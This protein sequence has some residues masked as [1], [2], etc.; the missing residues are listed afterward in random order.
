[1]HPCALVVAN[2]IILPTTTRIIQRKTPTPRTK[3]HP[4]SDFAV[5]GLTAPVYGMFTLAPRCCN[6][7]HRSRANR[8]NHPTLFPALYS[9]P[10]RSN[11]P[12]HHIH[13]CPHTLYHTE[14]SHPNHIHSCRTHHILNRNYHRRRPPASSI[15]LACSFHVLGSTRS[16]SV[17][18]LL[19]A[20]GCL[21]A[22]YMRG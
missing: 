11:S 8:T 18:F 6:C 22:G 17:A 10:H 12:C 20:V 19:Q 5:Q 9:T 3:L 14:Y 4:G 16:L 15:S 1:M 13:P 21:R 7:R 2:Y